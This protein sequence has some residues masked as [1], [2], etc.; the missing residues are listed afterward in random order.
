M[1]VADMGAATA[2]ATGEAAGTIPAAITTTAATA[3]TTDIT[4]RTSITD[5]ATRLSGL[6]IWIWL[7]L[8]VLRL[9]LYLPQCHLQLPL[10]RLPHLRLLDFCGI[11]KNGRGTHRLRLAEP[12]ALPGN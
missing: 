11:P 1:A 9:R 8:S 10:V 5:R 12:G 4:C 2:A 6:R 3:K 7:Q